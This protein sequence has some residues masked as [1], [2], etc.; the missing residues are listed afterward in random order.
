MTALQIAG[1]ERTFHLGASNVTLLNILF[2]TSANMTKKVVLPTN[3][4][5]FSRYFSVFGSL[6]DENGLCLRSLPQNEKSG[7]IRD[8]GSR[9]K[10]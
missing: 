8:K 5:E 1:C 10:K 3:R 2:E 6:V 7:R 4:V 9:R